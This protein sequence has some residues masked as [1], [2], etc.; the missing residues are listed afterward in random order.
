MVWVTSL[1][2][3]KSPGTGILFHKDYAPIYVEGPT[4]GSTRTISILPPG[5]IK[6]HDRV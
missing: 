3:I 4:L 5:K 2:R 6:D 1:V